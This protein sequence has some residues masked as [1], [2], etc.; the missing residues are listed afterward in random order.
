MNTFELRNL[1]KEDSF[2]RFLTISLGIHLFLAFGFALKSLVLPSETLIIQNAI[3]VDMVALPDKAEPQVGP[4]P[5]PEQPKVA[6][7]QPEEKKAKPEPVKEK[8]KETK[9]PDPKKA[10][11]D[12]LNKLKQKDAVERL[13]KSKPEPA[14]SAAAAAP[15]KNLNAGNQLSRGDSVT[16]LERIAFDE[17]ISQVKG[18]V[19]SNFSLPSWL[20]DTKF[21]ASVEVVIDADGKI[22]RRTLV[23]ESGNSTFDN[24]ALSA[25]DASNPFPAVPERLTRGWG[26]FTIQFNF[27][28]N[29]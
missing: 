26:S 25:V 6:P 4:S 24:A 2:K 9:K 16:G 18:A 10:Q 23:K 13:L 3:R 27:P 5:E 7:T 22:I 20:Q 19:N 8:P 12:A 11:L 17:Y 28:D 14:A 1:E 15:K 21:K 29:S